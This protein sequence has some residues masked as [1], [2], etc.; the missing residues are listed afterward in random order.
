MA[1]ISRKELAKVIAEKTLHVSD[2]KKLAQAVAAYFS[3]K[4]HGHVD[5]DSLMRDIMQYRLK[6]GHIEATAV[7]AHDL[8]DKVMKDISELLA[9]HFPDHKSIRVNSK[10]DDAVVGGV[11]IDLPMESLDLSVRSKLNTFKQLVAKERS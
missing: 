9:E 5:I 8:D 4:E 3:G 10:I 1:E 7:S 2:Q 6:K 11:R